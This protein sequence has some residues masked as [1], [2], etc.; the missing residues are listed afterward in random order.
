TGGSGDLYVTIKESHG[1]EQHFIVPYAT[2]PLLQREG[3]L[4]YALTVGRTR[5]SHTHSPQQNFAELTAL[6]GL[7]GGI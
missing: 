7:A 3:H 5:S 1:S 6:Y 2:V 4:K